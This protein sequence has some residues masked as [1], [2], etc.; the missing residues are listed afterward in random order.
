VRPDTKLVRVSVIIPTLNRREH[1]S[2]CLQSLAEQT[3]R[4]FEVVV[5]DGGSAD[6]TGELV[7]SLRAKLVT[8]S[9]AYIP[10]AENCGVSAAKGEIIAFTDDDVVV[11]RN[12][13][14]EIMKTYRDC[15]ADGVG[16]AIIEVGRTPEVRTP[17]RLRYLN[18]LFSIVVCENKRFETGLVLRSGHVTANFVRMKANCMTVDHLCG[19]NMSFRRRVFEVIGLFDEIYEQTAYRF[20]T[21]FCLRARAARFVLIYNPN[22]FVYHYPSQHVSRPRGRRLGHTL[23]SNMRNDTLFILR[24]RR[25]IKNFSWTRFVFRQVFQAGTNLWLAIRRKNI[26]YLRGVFGTIRGFQVWISARDT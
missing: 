2:K 9:R 10:N 23:F 3:Y 11:P 1:L 19:C 18:R 8:Q 6:G 5:A 21:D 14:E 22:V 17:S 7:A 24:G 12:W 26:A 4:D 25:H 15:R 16:G 13:L 20:E